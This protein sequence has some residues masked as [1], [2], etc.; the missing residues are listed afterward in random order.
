MKKHCMRKHS[1]L[2][3]LFVFMMLLT[4][5]ACKHEEWTEATCDAPRT[6]AE[7]GLTEGE[8]L[9]HEWQLANCEEPATCSRC[10]ATKG[11]AL[12][13][14]WTGATCE[15]AK[16]CEIC[17]KVDGEPNGHIWMDATC[18]KPRTCAICGKTE[19][20]A[21][22]KHD[23]EDATCEAPKTC[24]TCGKTDGEPLGHQW[25]EAT[26]N[27]PAVCE[28]CGEIGSSALNFQYVGTGNV[29]QNPDNFVP[30][31]ASPDLKA[32][33]N[34][35]IP[36]GTM[37][38]CYSPNVPGWYCITYDGKAGYI[39]TGVMSQLVN[40]VVNDT[41]KA[42]TD[43]GF[44]IKSISSANIGEKVT[45]G[46]FTL[47]S[48]FMSDK[49][50]PVEWVVLDKTPT[51]M[52]LLADR[53]L[54][55]KAFSSTKAGATWE[56]CTLRKWL[57]NEFYNTTFSS[58]EQRYI[59]TSTLDNPQ[60]PSGGTAGNSTLDKV[61]LLS[62]DEFFTYL[63]QKNYAA[64]TITWFGYWH[65]SKLIT[66]LDSQWWL[67]TMGTADGT[68]CEVGTNG[69]PVSTYCTDVTEMRDVRPA[70]WVTLN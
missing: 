44:D 54:E 37:L 43:T 33:K 40:T 64:T 50:S 17:G 10:G 68:A 19:G 30:M 62:Y 15:T 23:W 7:C 51:K 28:R 49:Y 45:F 12:G 22:G 56:N 42:R 11:E 25:A 55:A 53:A 29:K 46:R 48:S 38:K 16:H 57:N 27:M 9:G 41:S 52:L 5:C 21:T 58:N 47:S 2:A 6:C 66:G 24:K 61:F 65:R 20:S 32:E 63:N 26:V 36:C 4:G 31:Y 39:Q 34:G 8:P 18:D 60:N 1:F 70:I 67:R 35:E 3:L 59:L 69:Y 13:H 14:Q